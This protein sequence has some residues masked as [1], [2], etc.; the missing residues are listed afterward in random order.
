M[1]S[2]TVH[3]TNVA[4]QDERDATIRIATAHVTTPDI[5]VYLNVWFQHSN[6][7]LEVV[8]IDGS[9]VTCSHVEE[10]DRENLELPL[11]LVRELVERFGNS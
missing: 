4:V 7:L 5:G 10:P 3:F 1:L 8:A 2:F 6:S 9:N 11:Q